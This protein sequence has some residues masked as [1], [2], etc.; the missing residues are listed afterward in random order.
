MVFKCRVANL[1]LLGI[2]IKPP[3]LNI[4]LT[5]A[6][7]DKPVLYLCF[8]ISEIPLIQIKLFPDINRYEQ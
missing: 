1:P 3:A 8:K 7:L 6:V 4:L 5:S 2:K